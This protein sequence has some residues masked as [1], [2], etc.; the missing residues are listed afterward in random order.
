MCRGGGS[1]G[2]V[3]VLCALASPVPAEEWHLCQAG[4]R[5]HTVMVVGDLL[6]LLL[7]SSLSAS[8]MCARRWAAKGARRGDD[9]HIGDDV[10]WHTPLAACKSGLAAVPLGFLLHHAWVASGATHVLN[11][12]PD[13]R[14]SRVSVLRGCVWWYR[15]LW[16]V[17]PGADVSP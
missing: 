11:L 5:A 8:A 14:Q 6:L 7:V 15:E 16:Q 13:R 9:K 4:L 17:V 1:C 12:L 3:A 10:P 2:L